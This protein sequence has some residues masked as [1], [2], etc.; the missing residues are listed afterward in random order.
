[1][2]ARSWRFFINFQPWFPWTS[3]AL[4]QGKFPGL[5]EAGQLK[6]VALR[7]EAR[8]QG[9]GISWKD[10]QEH[11]ATSRIKTRERCVSCTA[12]IKV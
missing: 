11:L 9:S 6:F 12:I 2:E 4:K 5:C 7:I 3:Y 10:V 1:M 8:S